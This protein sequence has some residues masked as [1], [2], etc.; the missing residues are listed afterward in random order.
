VLLWKELLKY[1]GTIASSSLETVGISLTALFSF[2]AGQ[3]QNIWL[4]NLFLNQNA[5]VNT[6][7]LALLHCLLYQA[8]SFSLNPRFFTY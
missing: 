3:M 7:G 5:W 4:N 6:L 2:G 1:N 8:S